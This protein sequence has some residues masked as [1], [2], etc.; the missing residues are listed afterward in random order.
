M[1]PASDGSRAGSGPARSS[2]PARHD[3]RIRPAL[4]IDRPRRALMLRQSPASAA[5]GAAT[6]LRDAL[7]RPQKT[8]PSQGLCNARPVH[9]F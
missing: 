3:G 7:D 2:R 8:I 6:P 1:F 4:F 5:R 9:F